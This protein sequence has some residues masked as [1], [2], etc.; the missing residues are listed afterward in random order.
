MIEEPLQDCGGDTPSAQRAGLTPAK[1]VELS[2]LVRLK[3]SLCQENL[4]VKNSCLFVNDL[5]LIF[6]VVFLSSENPLE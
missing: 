1:G 5:I 2:L 6:G 3:A 4:V